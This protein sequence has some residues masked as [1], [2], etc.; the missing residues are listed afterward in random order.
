MMK[1]PLLLVIFLLLYV[2][3]YWLLPWSFGGLRA[4]FWTH[5]VMV[6]GVIVAAF[7]VKIT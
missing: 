5:G 6:A 2:C 7:F 1:N 4:V 3:C